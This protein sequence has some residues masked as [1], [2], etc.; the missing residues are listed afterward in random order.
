M[1]PR[2]SSLKSLANG[3][4]APAHSPT[5][6]RRRP[7]RPASGTSL[8]LSDSQ[9]KSSRPSVQ[10]LFLSAADLLAKTTTKCALLTCASGMAWAS[11]IVWILGPAVSSPDTT[12]QV[13]QH[14]QQE[15]P[16][17][18]PAGG[19]FPIVDE[20]SLLPGW[21]PLGHHS[22]FMGRE[23]F[24]EQFE[25][26]GEDQEVVIHS[27]DVGPLT[28]EG[29]QLLPRTDLLLAILSGDDKAAR[30][31]RDTI[32]ELYDKY[33]GWVTVGGERSQ[34]QNEET[35]E[36]EFQVIFVVTRS[37]APPDGELVGD[38][39]YVNAPDGYRNI[40]YKV[41][42]MMGLVRHIDF[43][44]LLKADDDTFVCV[45]RL[46]NFLHNQ[47][48]ESKDKI[49][50]GVPT[51]CNSPANPSVKVGRVIKDHKDKWYDQKFVHHT[52]AG[53]DCYPVYMQGAFYVLAQP[54]VEHLYRGR[55][56]YDTFINEDVTVGSWL[57]G[58]DRALGTIHDFE[59]SRLW[60]C[61]CGSNFVL[62]PAVRKDQA[63]CSFTTV[64]KQASSV[65]APSVSSGRTSTADS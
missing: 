1:P 34:E 38:V 47:P 25:H 15:V 20:G 62:R 30:L 29:D 17:L 10:R 12:T 52:L 49:Y 56:H 53:L 26:W 4:E 33:G 51:A 54:L 46:A 14:Q 45:E 63:R 13:D 5:G 28:D 43:K 18:S 50:A 2:L 64:R 22:R 37:T 6:S 7:R 8:H 57:L 44:F 32:R 19:S 42:H 21:T 55:E 24:P 11:L 60:N 40:V 65:S 35:V 3:G 59:S 58:V 39:L 48:E 9:Q 61:V 16:T 36:M 27:M 23:A 41:K 31:K